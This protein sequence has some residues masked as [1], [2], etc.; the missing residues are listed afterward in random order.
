M[1][2]IPLFSELWC[3]L[4]KIETIHSMRLNWTCLHIFQEKFFNI[5]NDKFLP[6]IFIIINSKHLKVE[7]R[8]IESPCTVQSASTITSHGQSYFSHTRSW[9]TFFCKG[10]EVPTLGFV[11][12]E[13]DRMLITYRMRKQISANFLSV[14]FK[15]W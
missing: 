4:C 15:M 13:V 12:Q 1:G 2:S 9:Q 11:A 10:A 5:F 14:K 8:Y 7:G 3:S 6:L